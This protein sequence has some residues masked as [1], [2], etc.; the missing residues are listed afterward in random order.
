MSELQAAPRGAADEIRGIVADL[1]VVDEMAY[2]S[3]EIVEAIFSGFT[4][5]TLYGCSIITTSREPKRPVVTRSRRR[6]IM[7]G[8]IWSY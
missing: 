4:G 1:I 7:T 5:T 6:R 2:A 8:R 3:A